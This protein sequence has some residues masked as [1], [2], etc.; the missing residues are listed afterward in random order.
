LEQRKHNPVP[1]A[2]DTSCHPHLICH[3]L[4]DGDEEKPA[5]PAAQLERPVLP[6]S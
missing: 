2:S 5:E 4:V 6:V 1:S 3:L